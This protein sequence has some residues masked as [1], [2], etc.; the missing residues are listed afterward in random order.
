[1]QDACK[2]FMLFLSGKVYREKYNNICSEL[3][4]GKIYRLFFIQ[5]K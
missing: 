1:M 3:K 2:D 4:Q 5:K